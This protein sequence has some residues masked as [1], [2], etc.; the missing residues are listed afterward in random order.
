MTHCISGLRKDMESINYEIRNIFIIIRLKKISTNFFLFDLHTALSV[1]KHIQSMLPATGN[2][3]TGA[4]GEAKAK[5][6]KLKPTL[7]SRVVDPVGVDIDPD[8]TRVRIGI[9]A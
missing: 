4:P 5:A 2:N 9:V 1:N 3:N 7:Q 6:K 8:S